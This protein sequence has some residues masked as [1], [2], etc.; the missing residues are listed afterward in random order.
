MV[1]YPAMNYGGT[2]TKSMFAPAS[3]NSRIR[4]VSSIDE[5]R[6]AAVDFDGSVFFFPDFSNKRIYTKQINIDGTAQLSM[7]ELSE[8]PVVNEAAYVTREEFNSTLVEIKNAINQLNTSP[9]PSEA[10]KTSSIMNF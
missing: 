10:E 9:Q 6:A 7:Y 3:Q 1:N 2:T 8:I 5:V 4:P